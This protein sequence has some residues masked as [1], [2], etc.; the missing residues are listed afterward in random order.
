MTNLIY[1][2][3]LKLVMTFMYYIRQVVSQSHFHLIFFEVR[4]IAKQKERQYN[5]VKKWE[6]T[7]IISR[8]M[9]LSYR[10]N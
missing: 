2:P 8:K 1:E 6:K 4:N 7:V 5:N 10:Q 3:S 9:T